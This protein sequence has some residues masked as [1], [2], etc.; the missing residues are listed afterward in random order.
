MVENARAAEMRRD[1]S[2]RA[3]AHIRVIAVKI[4]KSDRRR[5]SKALTPQ[6]GGGRLV[7]ERETKALAY[8]SR[9]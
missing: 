7:G 1:P 8:L 3:A 6:I 9:P 2:R 5:P 4:A